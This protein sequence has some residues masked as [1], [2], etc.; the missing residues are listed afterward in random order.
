MCDTIQKKIGLPVFDVLRDGAGAIVK[1][2]K[3]HVKDYRKESHAFK[4]DATKSQPE[5]YF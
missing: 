1:M 5:I 3:S 4:T 2:L